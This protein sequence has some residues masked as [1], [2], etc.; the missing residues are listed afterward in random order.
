MSRGVKAFAQLILPSAVVLAA[1][2]LWEDLR[3]WV[4]VFGFWLHFVAMRAPFPKVLLYFGFAP[5][6]DLL[7]TAVLRELRKRGKDRI[8]MVSDHRDLFL[9]NQDPAYLRPLWPRYYRDGSTISI[10]RRFVRIWGGEFTRPEYAPLDGMDRRRIPTRHIIA[11]MCARVG[12]TG[13]VAIRPYLVLTEEEKSLAAW[14]RGRIVIQSSGMAARHPMRNKE[15]YPDRV[16]DVVDALAG[17][18]EFIQLGSTSDPALLHAKDLRGGTSV[19]ETAAILSQ[20]RLY[21]GTVGFLMH[22]AR[23][24][25]CPSVIIFGGREAPWQSGYVC[26]TNLYTAVSCAPCWRANT[27]EFDRQCMREISGADVVSA[28][29]QM[30][31]RPRNPLAVETVDVV[32]TASRSTHARDPRMQECSRNHSLT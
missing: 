2:N 26:N 8:L 9:G 7:C 24:V 20:A 29:R 1:R 3:D 27:C 28:I 21:V 25:E 10:C 31:K 5:G 14:A 19:R 17:E 11:E 15:W 4:G 30:L 13:P 16:Q 32:P 12:I 23:A 6:D 22:V 18:V